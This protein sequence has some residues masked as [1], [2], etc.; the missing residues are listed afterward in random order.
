MN[1]ITIVAIISL[2]GIGVLHFY[3]A[4]GGKVWL[5]KS[6][7]TINGQPLFLPGKIATIVVGMVLIGFA[8]V[9]FALSFSDLHSALYGKYILYFGWVLSGIFIVRAIG[10]FNTIGF[11][12]KI[13]T[14]D[15]ALY[16]TR[17]YSPY[18]LFI[19]IVFALLSYQA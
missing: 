8:W 11:F 2:I 17:F 5:N 13:K 6:I 4:L 9:A 16:D 19:G 18:A 3:W 15:F 10:E 7:P 1:I 12:K 14:S